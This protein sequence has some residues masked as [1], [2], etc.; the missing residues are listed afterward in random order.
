MKKYVE[1]IIHLLIWGIGYF[2]ILNYTS[3]I[4]DFRKERGPYWIALLF[5]MLMNLSVFYTTA[6]FLVPK[7]LRLKNIKALVFSVLTGFIFINLFESTVDHGYLVNFFSSASESFF[8]T[9]LYNT[10][11]SFFILLLAL[12][13]SLIKYWVQNEKLKRVLLEEKLSTEMA[14]LK[15]KINPHFLFNVLNS[16]YAKSLKYNAPELANGIA[17]L[18]E[19]MRY[20]VYETNED[21][22]AL[23]KE[24]LHLKNFIQ[25]Y[26]LRIAEEDD[27]TISFDLKGAINAVQISP[28]LLI[29]FVENA[30]KHGIDPKSKSL[31]NISIVVEQNKLHFEVT[32]TLHQ[33]F[34]DLVDEPSGFGLDNLKKRLS[35]LYPNA[36]TLETKEVDGYFK[37]LL[38][39]QLDK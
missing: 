23:E 2:L 12:S 29:P 10:T 38:I 16:F 13:Y 20:M 11:V 36:Y 21:K 28:M 17:K 30:I 1:P 24:I 19:L 22:V 34:Y 27:V 33:S 9:F 35:I 39:L 5:G 7:F 3:T 15:S 14:F 25:V 31:I 32:N 8:V 18:A 6:Y 26:Q 37:S 4:G